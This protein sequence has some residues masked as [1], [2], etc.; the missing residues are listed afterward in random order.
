MKN[1]V[2]LESILELLITAKIPSLLILVTLMMERIRFS[3]TSALTRA[4]QRHIQEDGILSFFSVSG[5][6]FC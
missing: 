6:H 5:T 3:Q 1:A 4:T 2:F